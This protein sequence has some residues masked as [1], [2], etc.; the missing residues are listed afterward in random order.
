MNRSEQ[1]LL[2]Y[3]PN[4]YDNNKGMPAWR[5]G[6]VGLARV[7]TGRP[8]AERRAQDLTA[9]Q[10]FLLRIR[11][12]SRLQQ[13]TNMFIISK[14]GMHTSRILRHGN[15][16]FAFDKWFVRLDIVPGLCRHHAHP[17]T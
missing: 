13:K 6:A 12:R 3:W 5:R 9:S 10:D 8:T 2:S 11:D 17:F 7:A 1:R 15:D 14:T 16:C 4:L